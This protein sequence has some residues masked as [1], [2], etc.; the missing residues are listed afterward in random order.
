MVVFFTQTVRQNLETAGESEESVPKPASH[1]QSLCDHPALNLL[2][3]WKNFLI[4]VSKFKVT[5][6]AYLTPELT[7]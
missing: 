1:E 2:L 4:T 7:C 5:S 3:A 6:R